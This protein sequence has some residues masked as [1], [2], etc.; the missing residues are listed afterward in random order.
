MST[1]K[2]TQVIS[3]DKLDLYDKFISMNAEIKRKGTTL[4]YTSVNGNMFTFLSK[5]GK[6][7]IR[8]PAPDRESFITKFKTSP[9]VQHGVTMKEYVVVPE[10]LLK[11]TNELQLYVDRSFEY[12]KTLK[13]KT[14][15]KKKS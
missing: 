10:F 2:V 12:A 1:K 14:T 4:P 7:N 13:S 11:N 6:L 9:S 8:L 15:T 5:D 3:P